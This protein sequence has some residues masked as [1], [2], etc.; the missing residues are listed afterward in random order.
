MHMI[1]GDGKGGALRAARQ[2]SRK[3]LAL[4]LASFR[5][6]LT[7]HFDAPAT[8][9]RSVSTAARCTASH[10]V[11]N[12]ATTSTDSPRSTRFEIE[13]SG[14]TITLCQRITEHNAERLKLQ[15]FSR[16]H[17]PGGENGRDEAEFPFDHLIHRARFWREVAS[18]PLSLRRK[19]I[20]P[21]G[22]HRADFICQANRSSMCQPDA[23]VVNA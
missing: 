4:R 3:L 17:P 7:Q 11:A 20:A 12:S 5:A 19:V 18:H 16:L 10:A 6:L 22:I 8:P 21:L 2:L 23:V 15:R 14:K 13:V 9:Y 1:S